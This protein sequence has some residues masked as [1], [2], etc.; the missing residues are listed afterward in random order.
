MLSM[1]QLTIKIF[2]RAAQYCISGRVAFN[3]PSISVPWG[4]GRLRSPILA[5]A[6]AL[7]AASPALADPCKAIPD[8]GPMPAYLHQG[9]AFSGA[10]TYVGDG[11]S[12]CVAVGAGSANWVE[13][14]LADFYAP[15]LSAPDGQ[16]AK[17]ALESVALGKEVHCLAGRRSYDRIVARCA[18][19]S[20]NIG[21]L[22]RRAGIAEGGNGR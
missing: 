1:V 14:R 15:E 19:G 21:D 22:M 8:K 17:A 18:V 2:T 13:V 12:L 6:A 9:A 7:L 10:V 4:R 3:G 5:A 11:D 20:R 16:A